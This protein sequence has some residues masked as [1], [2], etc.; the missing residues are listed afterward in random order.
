MATRTNTTGPYSAPMTRFSAAPNATYID[1]EYVWYG[2]PAQPIAE[3]FPLWSTPTVNTAIAATGVGHASAI[4]L[5]AGMVVTQITYVTAVTAAVSPTA[6]YIALYDPAQSLCVSSGDLTSTARAANTVYTIPMLRPYTCP[7]TGVYYVSISFTAATVPTL[8]GF[9][10]SNGTAFPLS[11]MLG[12]G[13]PPMMSCS[14]GTALGGVAPASLLTAQ[15]S[16]VGRIWF[17]VS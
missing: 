16:V 1:S 17:L 3:S 11:G 15:A 2:Q 13:I 12:N 14:H 7:T 6:Q 9:T 10:Y 4:A 8:T 5:Q